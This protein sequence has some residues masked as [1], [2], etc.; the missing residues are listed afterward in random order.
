LFKSRTQTGKF[1]QY[2]DLEKLE[3]HMEDLAP[4]DKKLIAE[5]IKAAHRFSGYDLF[6]ALSGG[7]GEGFNFDPSLAPKGK[8]VLKVVFD[9][10]DEYWNNPKSRI[11]DTSKI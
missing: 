5:F 7:I 4:S 3:K 2:T 6:A 11:P 1:S 8:T 10:E 9:S